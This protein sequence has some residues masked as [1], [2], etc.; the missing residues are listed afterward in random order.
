MTIED[1]V[2]V[3]NGEYLDETCFR[4]LI[5]QECVWW[6]RGLEAG[7][8]GKIITGLTKE[9][10][11]LLKRRGREK[12]KGTRDWFHKTS[13][14]SQGYE[15]SSLNWKLDLNK[16]TKRNKEIRKRTW[17]PWENYLVCHI[18]S[19][20]T[21]AESRWRF[22]DAVGNAILAPRRKDT[23]IYLLPPFRRG[24][25][26]GTQYVEKEEF[27]KRGGCQPRH[28]LYRVQTWK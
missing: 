25:C 20:R 11:T 3:F 10:A 2:F 22:L 23:V 5:W 9:W 13:S 21:C 8:W 24:M 1:Y 27:S 15:T 28:L 19:L 7:V 16:H 26:H 4:M 12:S 14:L 18:L 6:I 17:F